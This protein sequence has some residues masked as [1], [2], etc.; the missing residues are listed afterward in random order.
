MCKDQGQDNLHI[1]RLTC[2]YLQLTSRTTHPHRTQLE[3]QW[4]LHPCALPAQAQWTAE[5][6]LACANALSLPAGAPAE[7][8]PS[9]LPLA[10][11][12]SSAKLS[13]LMYSTTSYAYQSSDALS[14]PLSCFIVHRSWICFICQSWCSCTRNMHARHPH[15]CLE[16]AALV[17]IAIRFPTADPGCV[18][19]YMHASGTLHGMPLPL[20]LSG[21]L[22][23][24]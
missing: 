12:Q 8:Q 23:P 22:L 1:A 13:R 19:H 2:N 4:A 10:L 18:V 11:S 21:R 6:R 7:V 24:P 5:L 17:M 15:Y 16:A 3:R 20:H 9:T 14:V